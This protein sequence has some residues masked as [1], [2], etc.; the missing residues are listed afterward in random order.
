M[1]EV[2]CFDYRINDQVSALERIMHLTHVETQ[3]QWQAVL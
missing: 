2:G 3:S 1:M